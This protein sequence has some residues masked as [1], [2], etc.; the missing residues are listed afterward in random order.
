M[1][2]PHR[3]PPSKTKK[4]TTY[5]LTVIGW[6]GIYFFCAYAFSACTAEL[7]F[8]F[9]PAFTFTQSISLM[10]VLSII[11]FSLAFGRH[12]VSTLR[13]KNES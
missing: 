7:S 3:A 8:L 9:I 1:G 12:A 6:V 5:F 10:V 11:G 13:S 2:S 4:V